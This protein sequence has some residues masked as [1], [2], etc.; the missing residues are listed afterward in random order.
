MEGPKWQFNLEKASQKSA[1]TPLKDP[2]GFKSSTTDVVVRSNSSKS[3]NMTYVEVLEAK[4]WAFAKS[5]SG[6]IFQTLIMFYMYGS[7]VSLF[8]IMF[9]V[10][11][12]T[13][14]IKAI[15]GMNA[16]FEQFKHKDINLLLPKLLYFAIQLGLLGLALY[17]FSV[18]G[19][20][21][22]TT[23]DWAGI[24]SKRTPA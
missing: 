7:G 2:L 4:A 1:E 18:M 10:H 20:I 19:V 17:K 6:Q 13:G 3:S 24:I 9:T 11:F 12:I 16:Q 14:P 23:N 15:G 8:S 21:P 22:V 5:P